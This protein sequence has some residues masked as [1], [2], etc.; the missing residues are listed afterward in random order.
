[1]H[2]RT[3]THGHMHA[4]TTETADTQEHTAP[5]A[6][7]QSHDPHPSNSITHKKVPKLKQLIEKGDGQ[8]AHHSEP[9]GKKKA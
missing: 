9:I 5:S 1:M 2:A 3:Y 6:P 7:S 8:R 4:E